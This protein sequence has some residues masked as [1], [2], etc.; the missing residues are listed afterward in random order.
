M[1]SLV[2]EVS[3]VHVMAKKIMRIAHLF[4]LLLM[5]LLTSCTT[6]KDTLWTPH[7]AETPLGIA[8]VGGEENVPFT[9]RILEENF[10]GERLHVQARLESKVHWNIDDATI[11]LRGVHAGE[12]LEEKSVAV[13]D[14]V[15]KPAEDT[16]GGT[17]TVYDTVLSIPAATIEDYQ[18]ELIWGQEPS[19]MPALMTALAIKDFKVLPR[20]ECSSDPCFYRFAVEGKL[21]N[22]G[23]SLISQAELGVG[24]VF[25][26][27]GEKVDLS[28][29]IPEDEEVLRLPNVMLAAGHFKAFKLKLDQVVPE[30]EQ[31]EF[32][33]V[34]RVISYQ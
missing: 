23:N 6:L 19:E 29:I 21:Y 16:E 34:V 3:R 26:K 28:S 1:L 32:V 4:L 7:T 20:L 11:W 18:L 27:K 31:G 15:G 17:V 22:A 5:V 10:D 2:S 33:P 25:V 24:Y 13:K 14:L 8:E 12:V 30:V 9:L